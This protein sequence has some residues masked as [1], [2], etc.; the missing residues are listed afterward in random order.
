MTHTTTDTADRLRNTDTLKLNGKPLLVIG[1][2]DAGTNAR[3]ARLAITVCDPHGSL[4]DLD[5]GHVIHLDA[6]EIVT[7][8]PGATHLADAAGRR[9]G[10]AEI[11]PPMASAARVIAEHCPQC[12]E[13]FYPAQPGSGQ[14]CRRCTYE[15]GLLGGA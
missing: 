13:V 8:K 9:P 1:I 2:A 3:P 11:H 12:G 4:A 10:G 5:A 15:A 14:Q 7:F 6:G